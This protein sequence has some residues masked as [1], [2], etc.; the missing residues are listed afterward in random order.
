[1]TDQYGRG[2]R[3]PVIEIL[4]IGRYTIKFLL[5]ECHISIANALR[6]IMIADVPTMA[7]DLVYINDNSSVLHDEFLSHRLGL[8][9]FKS[10]TVDSYEFFRECS[11]KPSCHKCSVEFN[12]RETALDDVKDITTDHINANNPDCLVKP[13]KY[14][15]ADGNEEDPILIVKLAKNQKVDIQCIVRKGTGKEHAKWS[16]VATVQVQQM[17]QI[18]ISPSLEEDLDTE[19]KIGLVNSCPASVYKLN[20]EKQTVDIETITDCHQCQECTIYLENLNKKNDLLK[21]G[22]HEDHFIFTVESTGALPP[23]E[24]VSKAFTILIDKMSELS[25]CTEESDAKD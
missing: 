21:V 17:P 13:V 7:I 2:L 8:I 18:D 12:L 20:A 9:P 3:A 14:I 1:M 10:D 5:K 16:P 24:I 22:Q 11:C 4:D 25:Q 6:R 15:N 23:E 19:E